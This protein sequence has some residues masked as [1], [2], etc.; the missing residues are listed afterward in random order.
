MVVHSKVEPKLNIVIAL[1]SLQSWSTCSRMTNIRVIYCMCS[2]CCWLLMAQV[3]K[4]VEAKENVIFKIS[5]S[6]KF[7][8]LYCM[9][10]QVGRHEAC[11]FSNKHD[12]I[13]KE[14]W[15][16]EKPIGKT[17]IWN[18]T[19]CMYAQ[20]HTYNS[21][22]SI[23]FDSHIGEDQHLLFHSAIAQANWWTWKEWWAFTTSICKVQTG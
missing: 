9:V 1:S 11:S 3:A 12:H 18:V 21:R 17:Q 23:V 22:S 19:P 4:C 16:Q 15:W 10:V 14:E 5:K 2:K 8:S 13:L 6:K 20:S 7:S